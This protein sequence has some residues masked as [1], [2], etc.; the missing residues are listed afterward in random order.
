MCLS[1]LNTFTSQF[2]RTFNLSLLEMSHWQQIPMQ[3]SSALLMVYNYLWAYE[4][5]WISFYALNIKP[6]WAILGDLPLSI[7]WIFHGQEL[8]SK[9]GIETTKIGK[10]TNI[11]TIEN[12]APFHMGNYTCVAS[13]D[14]G[15]TNYTVPLVVRG[16]YKT[17][18][19][20]NN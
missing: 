1:F 6:W 16:I 2:L 9:M 18:S 12:I 7:R 11:L 8:S 15:A 20:D 14:A 13:N 5:K 10:R 17:D 3:R 4:R 19:S